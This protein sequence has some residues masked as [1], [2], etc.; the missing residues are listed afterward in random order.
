MMDLQRGRAENRGVTTEIKSGFGPQA[1]S[2]KESPASIG[3]G[4]KSAA[5][6]KMVGPDGVQ[7]PGPGAYDY[8]MVDKAIGKQPLAHG[9]GRSMPEIK[10]PTGARW[11][12]STSPTK[13]PFKSEFN[14]PGPDTIH[15]SLDAPHCSLGK[16]V[17]TNVYGTVVI[18]PTYTESPAPGAYEPQSK[19]I[20]PQIESHRANSAATKVGKSQRD[21]RMKMFVSKD[22]ERELYGRIGPGP[23]HLIPSDSASSKSKGT[24]GG[25]WGKTSG[26]RFSEVKSKE[27]ALSGSRASSPSKIGPGT[28][29]V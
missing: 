11:G 3:I 13:S 19:S 2:T 17:R 18:K 16:G 28:Y 14:T 27:E 7:N 29:R 12:Q 9:K 6:Y 4:R 8:H 21:D 15:G 24:P 20:G 1:L 23:G 5:D 10:V 26:D 25:G 22:A